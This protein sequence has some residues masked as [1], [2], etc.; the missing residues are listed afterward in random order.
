[1]IKFIESKLGDMLTEDIL[2]ETIQILFAEEGIEYTKQEALTYLQ[3]NEYITEF[4]VEP[5]VI[6]N[7][8]DIEP[9]VIGDW[10]DMEQF[11][12]DD[13][14]DI[15]IFEIG[16]WWDTKIGKSI[17]NG[18]WYWTKDGSQILLS[19]GYIVE[20]GTL[21]EKDLFNTLTDKFFNGDKQAA[22]DTLKYNGYIY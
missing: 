14:W 9:F 8:W 4:K 22:I 15:E 2:N 21:L 10:W 5:F 18:E 12:T 17:T 3:Q 1:M 19:E 13:W 7:W 20:S 6:G 11:V 16:D